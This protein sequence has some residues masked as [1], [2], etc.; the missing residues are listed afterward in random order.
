MIRLREFFHKKSKLKHSNSG[1]VMQSSGVFLPSRGANL[2]RFTPSGNVPRVKGYVSRLGRYSYAKHFTGYEKTRIRLSRFKPSGAQSEKVL[3]NPSGTQFE[4]FS[5]RTAPQPNAVNLS[6][7][8]KY[9]PANNPDSSRF[10]SKSANLRRF[11]A[12]G[13]N[14]RTIFNAPPKS[15]SRFI[16]ADSRFEAKKVYRPVRQVK[17]DKKKLLLAILLVLTVIGI[18]FAVYFILKL[19][20]TLV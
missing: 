16:G 9:G 15:A 1:S 14:R 18:S 11:P 10:R 7:L 2:T 12:D 20:P 5:A 13:T 19:D 8:N 6:K 4:K 3:S 17:I